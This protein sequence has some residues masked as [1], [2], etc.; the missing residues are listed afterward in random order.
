MTTS[1]LWWVNILAN[2]SFFHFLHLLH[3]LETEKL[4]NAFALLCSR[5]I[6]HSSGAGLKLCIYCVTFALKFN[7]GHKCI[8]IEEKDIT[9]Y[10]ITFILYIKNALNLIYFWS[11]IN[12]SLVSFFQSWTHPSCRLPRSSPRRRSENP[13]RLLPTTRSLNWKNVSSTKNIF[14]RLTG[15]RLQL[16]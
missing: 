14:R 10:C 3:Y 12:I 9:Y 15:M 16:N 2:Y 5:I 13:G 7:V 4:S 8:Q 11:R 1:V 6:K